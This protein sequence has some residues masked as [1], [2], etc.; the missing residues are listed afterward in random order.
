MLAPL[1]VR[2]PPRTYGGIERVVYDLTQGLVKDNYKVVLFASGDSQTS[3]ELDSIWPY[4]LRFDKRIKNPVPLTLL[5]AINCFR[6]ANDFDL[7]HNHLGHFGLSFANFVKKPILTTLHGI[8]PFD[9]KPLFRAH[10]ELPFV[11][12][13]NNQRRELPELNYVATVYNGTDTKLYSFGGKPKDYLLFMGRSSPEK[14]PQLAIDIAEA[15]KMKLIMALRVNPE[16]EEFYEKEVKPRLKKAKYVKLLG[17][18]PDE[19][20]VRLYQEA[21]ATLFP[22]QWEEP[23]GLVMT[24]SMS[25]G[26]PVI[27]T[28]IGSVPEVI[29]DGVTGFICRDVKEA[30]KAVSKISKISRQACREHVVKNFSIEKMVKDYQKVYSKILSARGR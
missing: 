6:K 20:R 17:P 23:F 24:E 11:S 19:E 28:R 15:C 2:V 27:A 30:I 14:G 26:T 12:I 18:I 7:I 22:I 10:K 4:S 5:H 16:D 29:V 25:C 1:V 8:I 9:F 13:S 21:K 3:A